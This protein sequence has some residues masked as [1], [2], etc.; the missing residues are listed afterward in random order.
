[1]DIGDCHWIERVANGASA[2]YL[3]EDGT[4]QKLAMV[5]ENA[6]GLWDAFIV[7]RG[8]EWNKAIGEKGDFFLM[9]VARNVE[10]AE[11]ARFGVE[12]YLAENG[13][14]TPPTK[15][16]YV[17]RSVPPKSAGQKYVSLPLV[18]SNPK[19]D[20]EGTFMI[21]NGWDTVDH[22]TFLIY[23]CDGDEDA[24]WLLDWVIGGFI[25]QLTNTKNHIEKPTRRIRSGAT[26]D[27]LVA[28]GLMKRNK[29]NHYDVNVDR[30]GVE[31]ELWRTRLQR[32]N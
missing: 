25:A 10:N 22:R 15:T 12:Y 31:W 5:A 7:L 23:L 1:M 20:R 11:A 9:E 32:L 18:N 19:Q 27:K 28:M 13:M 6:S 21:G 24:A 3:I 14:P 17:I 8:K 4:E 29:D 2:H 26:N 16:E 30:I